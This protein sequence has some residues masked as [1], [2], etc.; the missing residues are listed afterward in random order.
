MLIGALGVGGRRLNFCSDVVVWQQ[1]GIFGWSEMLE[2]LKIILR[3]GSLVQNQV[4]S[5]SIGFLL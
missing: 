5:V 3:T 4:L 2:S 1:H